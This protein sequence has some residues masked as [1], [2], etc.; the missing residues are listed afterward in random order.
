MLWQETNA[1]VLVEPKCLVG[2][3]L[4]WVNGWHATAWQDIRALQA[5]ISGCTQDSFSVKKE[6]NNTVMNE[7]AQ[8]KYN[9][10]LILQNTISPTTDDNYE[11][12]SRFSITPS[13]NP[14]T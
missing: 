9:V 13:I 11:Q 1:G 3:F 7:E 2:W 4:I 5:S 12:Q 10:N 14:Q 6:A 8:I